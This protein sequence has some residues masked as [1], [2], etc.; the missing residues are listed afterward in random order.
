M[1]VVEIK[2]LF[3]FEN[4]EK[5]NQVF[6]G[7]RAHMDIMRSKQLRVPVILEHKDDEMIETTTIEYKEPTSDTPR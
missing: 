2:T 4:K 6:N 5:F 1:I 7:K 3:V